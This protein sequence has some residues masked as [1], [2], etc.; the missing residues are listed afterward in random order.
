MQTNN[1]KN[2]QNI[3]EVTNFEQLPEMLERGRIDGIIATPS[4][5][6]S[7]TNK[8]NTMDSFA[9]R[10]RY[11]EPLHFLFSKESVPEDVV[12]NFNKELSTLLKKGRVDAILESYLQLQ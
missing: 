6:K 12:L 11:Q 9:V 10:A 7:Y 1:E 4:S 3:V 5:L 8:T 2:K